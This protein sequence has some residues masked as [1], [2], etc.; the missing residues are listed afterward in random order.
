VGVKRGI[1]K[2]SPQ[3]VLFAK[4][5]VGGG[6]P[7]PPKK[8]KQTLLGGPPFSNPAGTFRFFLRVCRRE[9]GPIARK[10][11]V[12]VMQQDFFSPFPK[13]KKK[14]KKPSGPIDLFFFKTGGLMGEEISIRE[15]V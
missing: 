2:Q 9:E 5:E 6:P 12:N 10:W 7:P 8:K 4:K 11:A 3:K 1:L 14:K 15:K 13:K